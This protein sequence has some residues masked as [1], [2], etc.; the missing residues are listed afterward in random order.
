[1]RRGGG[2]DDKVDL[3][4]R[5]FTRLFQNLAESFT[6]HRK[7]ERK[8]NQKPQRFDENAEFLPEDFIPPSNLVAR[9]EVTWP[10]FVETFG[11]IPYATEGERLTLLAEAAGI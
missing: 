3:V 4:V 9:L 10:E 5:L 8:T 2:L 7:G 1:M 11:G 6:R